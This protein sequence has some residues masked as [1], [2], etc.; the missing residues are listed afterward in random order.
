MRAT[1]GMRAAAAVAAS[2]LVLPLLPAAP[3]SADPDP[4]LIAQTI[5]ASAVKKHLTKLQQIADT[6]GHTRAAGTPGHVASRDYV[7]G[8]LKKAGYKVTLQAF[9]F[10]FF[11]ENATATLERTAPAPK[12]YAPTPPDGS[13]VGEFATMTYSGSGDVTTAVRNVDLMLPPGRPPA[14]PPPAVRPPTSPRSRPAR[15]RWCSAAPAPSRSRRRTRRP[16]EPPA[17]SS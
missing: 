1:L 14:V 2:A 12:T 16:P 4:A 10:P 17:S 13:T 11:K 9:E 6:N 15:S 3:A 8:V 5:V 7:A